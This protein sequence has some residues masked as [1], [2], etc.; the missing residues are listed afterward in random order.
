[1]RVA[2]VERRSGVSFQRRICGVTLDTG[3]GSGDA[4]RHG[5]SEYVLSLVTPN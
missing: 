1:M 3:I 2:V 4:F 5:H